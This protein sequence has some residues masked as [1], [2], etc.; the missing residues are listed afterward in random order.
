MG[1]MSNRPEYTGGLL[2]WCDRIPLGRKT[3]A[4]QLILNTPAGNDN[5][6][7]KEMSHGIQAVYLL[8][9]AWHSL[10]TLLSVAWSY[11]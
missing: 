9:S 7:K 4:V 5:Q 1:K 11:F 8:H 6:A 10:L 2:F 3:R